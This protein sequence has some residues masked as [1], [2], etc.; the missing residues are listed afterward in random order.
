MA[1]GDGGRARAVARTIEELKEAASIVEVVGNYVELK[2][3]SPGGGTEYRGCC[4][5]HDDSNPSMG[6][7]EDKGLYYCFSCHA[8]G[9]V[10]NFVKEIEGITFRESVSKVAEIAN[11]ELDLADGPVRNNSR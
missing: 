8:S 10:I 5:F 7:T 2:P 3:T 11:I 1:G 6:V 9:D 4:P